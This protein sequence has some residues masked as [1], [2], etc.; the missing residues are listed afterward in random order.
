MYLRDKT[1][2]VKIKAH[3]ILLL[4]YC[5]V[6][7]LSLCARVRFLI[8]NLTRVLSTFP[9]DK[10]THTL[11]DTHTHTH[12]LTHIHIYINININIY[13]YTTLQSDTGD[14]YT[15]HIIMYIRENNIYTPTYRW[16]TSQHVCAHTSIAPC[17]GL[18]NNTKY[19]NGRRIQERCNIGR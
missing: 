12:S 11:T 1:T 8:R 10:T 2:T 16:P 7:R 18:I 15:L 6:S 17:P 14:S 19:I 3:S 13:V 4:C 9:A 5:G